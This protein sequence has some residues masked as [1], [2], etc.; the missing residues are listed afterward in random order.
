M[1]YK[2]DIAL[3]KL[4][5]V[6][7]LGSG[8]MVFR[9]IEELI[10][11]FRATSDVCPRTRSGFPVTEIDHSS[12]ILLE[13]LCSSDMDDMWYGT[14]ENGDKKV[15]IH[16]RRLSPQL[17]SKLDVL[18]ETNIMQK[19]LHD[20]VVQLYGISTAKVPMYVITEC[21]ENGS[22]LYYLREGDGKCI[23]FR[24]RIYLAAQVACG[25]DYLNSQ[26][27]VHRYICDRNMFLSKVVCGCLCGC[28]GG[29]GVDGWMC[30]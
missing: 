9:N 17:H 8:E 27:C 11:H 5:I 20:N 25:I 21:L 22:L 3:L 29:G 23:N 7:R 18:Q 24:K 16:I 4:C 12:L 10:R 19:L 15:P 13:R 6:Y 14:W 30:L 28:V 2:C 26:L 1:V